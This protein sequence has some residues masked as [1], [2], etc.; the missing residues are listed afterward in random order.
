MNITDSCNNGQEALDK[1]RLAFE[2]GDCSYGLIFMDISM[3]IMNGFE[4]TDK[5]RKFMRINQLEQPLVVAC[6]GHTEDEYI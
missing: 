2:D 3:P 5:I 6:T 1:V 4:A